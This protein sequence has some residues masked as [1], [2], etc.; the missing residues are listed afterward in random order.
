LDYEG[1]EEEE[2]LRADENEYDDLEANEEEE[3]ALNGD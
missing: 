2:A 3:A 1:D